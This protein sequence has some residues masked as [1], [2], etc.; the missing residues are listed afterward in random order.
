MEL[1]LN[2]PYI[3]M[4]QQEFIERA[5][6]AKLKGKNIGEFLIK[7]IQIRI[8][9][10][11]AQNKFKELTKILKKHK[12][13]KAL[14]FN[15]Y[16][17]GTRLIH[18][19][20]ENNDIYSE[21]LTGSTPGPQRELIFKDFRESV[22][23]IIETT[24]V[25]DEGINV[26]DCNVAIIF[27]GRRR[28]RQMIQRIG[29]ACRYKKY[30]IE[31]AYELVVEPEQKVKEEMK[32]ALKIGQTVYIIGGSFGKIGEECIVE[33]FTSTMADIRSVKTGEV[34]DKYIHNISLSPHGKPITYK[35]FHFT[36]GYSAWKVLYSRFLN[37]EYNVSE[38]RNPMEVIGNHDTLIAN[39]L[40]EQ[41][42]MP[43]CTIPSCKD[44]IMKAGVVY[45]TNH[46]TAQNKLRYLIKFTSAKTIKDLVKLSE[47]D[48]FMFDLVV[49]GCRKKG[50]K[51]EEVS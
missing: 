38:E 41:K 5:T 46:Q 16:I 3:Q 4:K 37:Y 44:K 48:K 24:T 20:L 25:L 28:R 34:Y 39:V 9:H 30:K 18:K 35:K 19:H 29:R 2:H 22:S 40:K 32:E 14:I 26:P 45:C 23:G 21:V 10:L 6:K 15:E 31:Y 47:K 7:R 13:S 11:L 43:K 42:D 17:Y 50:I 1:Y 33:K 27:N 8:I 36:Y 12:H 49:E 51:I